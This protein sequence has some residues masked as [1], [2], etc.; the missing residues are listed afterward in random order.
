[1]IPQN[2]SI[3]DDVCHQIGYFIMSSSSA[4]YTE[5]QTV[6]SPEAK[7][8]YWYITFFQQISIEAH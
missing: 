6:K 7:S 8:H 5:Q 3:T 2:L 1:M 4:I